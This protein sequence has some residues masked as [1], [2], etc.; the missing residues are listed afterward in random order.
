MK[1]RRYWAL[2]LVVQAMFSY[3]ALA[4]EPPPAAE[5]A[6]EDQALVEEA[7][8]VIESGKATELQLKEAY[9][10]LQKATELNPENRWAW[11][12][13]ARYHAN[14]GYLGPDWYRP[15]NLAQAI[16]AIERAIKVD[17]RYSGAYVYAGYLYTQAGQL[18]L[19]QKSFDKARE[20]GSN[21]DWLDV[22]Q[23]GLYTAQG[24][25]PEAEQLLRQVL[26][27]GVTDKALLREVYRQLLITY[28]KDGKVLEAKT[29][30]A[31]EAK[32]L[33]VDPFVR[34]NFALFLTEYPGAFDEALT[35]AR[36]A[37][38][39][40]DAFDHKRVL[41]LVLYG[42][43]AA[44]SQDEK[45][46][47]DTALTEAERLYPMISA[48]GDSLLD[49][50][51]LKVV[52]GRFEHIG[53]RDASGKPQVSQYMLFRMLS[54][55][56][57]E[58]WGWRQ[59]AP[60][61]LALLIGILVLDR[62]QQRKTAPGPAVAAEGSATPPVNFQFTGSGG[63]YFRIWIVNLL[64]TVLTLG[65]YSAWAK[66][67]KLKYFYRNT[68]V[69]DSRFDYHGDPV[70]ILKGRFIAIALLLAYKYGFTFSATLG[71]AT[72]ALLA[73]L[74]PW[75][76][77]NSMRFR[78]RNSSYRGIR[79]GF[80][81][82]PLGAYYVF[83]VGT[84][85][86]FATLYALGPFFHQRLKRYQHDY[87]TFGH[88]QSSFHAGP[89]QFYKLYLKALGVIFGAGALLGL[90]AAAGFGALGKSGGSAMLPVA[91]AGGFALYALF[92]LAF[93]PYV[94]SRLQ[95]L[96]WNHTSLG[97]HRF[98]CEQSA[99]QLFWIYLSNLLGV[100][101]TAGF[102]M[103]W[104]SVRLA[105][106]KAQSLSLIPDGSLDEAVAVPEPDGSAAG[107][108]ATEF[109]DIDISL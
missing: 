7:S 49:Q 44:G 48:A 79:F 3:G 11:Y 61:G 57:L 77:R 29:A 53:V 71:L 87:S 81:G 50:P 16:T 12:V 4:Q 45:T 19:A 95:N 109:F 14:S 32:A 38:A 92:I 10:Q 103:P 85:A 40:S 94:N 96:I 68:E 22:N 82:S 93:A 34:S 76:I 56:G 58:D 52:K 69:A 31:E 55:Y 62:S 46:K 65:I 70:A 91:L 107:Q 88:L 6:S 60:F 28:C 104:A 39:M 106:Y 51:G 1:I 33:P 102:F 97:P 5:P 25:Y 75:L 90:L 101:L 9:R 73:A 18:E 15:E 47:A 21:D 23:A 74:L 41:A 35:P 26:S 80:K 17:A 86:S 98:R 20:L 2:A 100:V 108:E 72:A 24:K 27:D 37:V 54:P 64:L 63:E 83:L 99:R 30:Y 67:R 105:R 8:A 42:Q 59:W 36:E 78:L 43:W 66:V 84:I 13:M 89:A